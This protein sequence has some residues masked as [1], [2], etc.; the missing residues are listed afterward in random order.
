MRRERRN[1]LVALILFLAGTNVATAQPE[2]GKEGAGSGGD[3]VRLT[4]EVSWGMPGKGWACRMMSRRLRRRSRNL[5]W[6]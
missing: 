6:S 4:V 3:V 2:S 1:V 5:S